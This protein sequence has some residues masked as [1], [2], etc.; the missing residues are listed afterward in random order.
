MITRRVISRHNPLFTKMRKYDTI[1]FA[2]EMPMPVYYHTAQS[3]FCFLCD[4]YVYYRTYVQ[5][6]LP[7]P[8]IIRKQTEMLYKYKL[9]NPDGFD[10]RFNW[11]SPINDSTRKPFGEDTVKYSLWAEKVH[12]DGQI[13]LHPSTLEIATTAHQQTMAQLAD[14]FV[15]LLKEVLAPDGQTSIQLT[16]L[17]NK[18]NC[19]AHIDRL[20]AA[21]NICKVMLIPS[22]D[23]IN[24]TLMP[25]EIVLTLTLQ[26]EMLK[27][28]MAD[29]P[30]AYAVLAEYLPPY[31]VIVRKILTEQYS[32]ALTQM[33][34][35][36]NDAL[37]SV[38]TGVWMSKHTTENINTAHFPS[39]LPLLKLWI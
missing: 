12:R 3:L 26:A 1:D 10:N 4:P 14:G 8:P 16:A 22:L 30:W 13:P 21:G 36:V 35:K 31:R 27:K 18:S 7:K 15:P 28:D 9:L 19:Y 5:E 38:D 37:G 23:T 25:T 17:I 2:S 34:K 32:Q 24:D 33:I 20:T 6:V 11:N 39:T 29:I